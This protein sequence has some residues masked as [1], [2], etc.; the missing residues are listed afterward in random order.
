MKIILVLFCGILLVSPWV[1]I[2]W[3]AIEQFGFVG[4]LWFIPLGAI[5]G[6][7]LLGFGG[8]WLYEFLI[9][10]EDRRTGLP[11]VGSFGGLGRAIVELIIILFGGWIGSIC[12]AWL[13]A[14][15][16]LVL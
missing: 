12:G 9:M 10:L 14:N 2:L 16:W 5:G 1:I 3:G 4:S 7:V 13:V 8:G 11:E 6:A 15:F